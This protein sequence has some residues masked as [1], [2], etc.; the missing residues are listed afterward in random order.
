MGTTQR[1]D[2][3]IA[4]YSSRGP[5]AIDGVLKPMSSA[6]GNKIVAAAAPGSYLVQTYPERVVADHGSNAYIEL[7]GTSMAAAMV[8]GETALLLEAT[9][10]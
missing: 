1:S 4:S 2:D 10:R 9:R 8:S 7:S 3:V 6:P 5:T